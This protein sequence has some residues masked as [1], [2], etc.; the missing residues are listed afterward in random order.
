MRKRTNMAGLVSHTNPDGSSYQT[1]L[2]KCLAGIS[3]VEKTINRAY[4]ALGE[5]TRISADSRYKIVIF[6]G[7]PMRLTAEEYDRWCMAYGQ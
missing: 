6:C 3:R 7:K 2:N 1:T 5:K 4:K